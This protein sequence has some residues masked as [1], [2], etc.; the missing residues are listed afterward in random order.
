MIAVTRSTDH[1]VNPYEYLWRPFLTKYMLPYL[2]FLTTDSQCVHVHLQH[3]QH[4]PPH[5][6]SVASQLIEL[7]LIT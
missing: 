5:L 2:T 4:H 1:R 7:R 6:V 3:P